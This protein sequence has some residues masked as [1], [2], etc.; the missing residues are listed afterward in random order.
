MLCGGAC[1]GPDACFGC[2][3]VQGRVTWFTTMVGKKGTLRDMRALLQKR[4]VPAVRTTEFVQVPRLA[5]EP[6]SVPCCCDLEGHV[7]S[8]GHVLEGMVCCMACTSHWRQLHKQHANL[9]L[10]DGWKR[11]VARSLQFT[12]SGPGNLS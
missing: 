9:L 2:V 4:R 6:A 7:L 1:S 11:L 12:F 3:R 5:C 10:Q 8:R